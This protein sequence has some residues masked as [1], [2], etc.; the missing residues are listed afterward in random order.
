LYIP[1]NN[2]LIKEAGNAIIKHLKKA[3]IPIDNAKITE[4]LS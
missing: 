4:A 1:F 3:E 2:S